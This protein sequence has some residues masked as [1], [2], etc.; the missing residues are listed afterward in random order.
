MKIVFTPN[1]FLG[2]DVL[3]ETFSFAVLILFF[4]LCIKNYKLSKN[5]N[6][7]YLGIGFFIIAFAEIFTILTKLILY[8]DTNFT[9]QIGHLIV[10]YNVVKS[11]DIFYYIGFFLHKFFTLSGLYIIYKI[12]S[13]KGTKGDFLLGIG[14]IIISAIFGNLFYYVFH[15]T[16]LLI[17]GLIISNYMEIYQENKSE[18]TKILITAFSLLALSQLIFILSPLSILYVIGQI[19]QLVSYII[20][21]VLI[22]RIT[23]H[24]P[25]KKS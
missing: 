15:L 7:F 9:Q 1:W 8:Y 24:G 18:N 3:I 6:S 10:T 16:V 2:P 21:L 13:K 20:L 5:K 19:I 23:K 11:V 17:L 22:I 4:V 12:P 25:K 14:F